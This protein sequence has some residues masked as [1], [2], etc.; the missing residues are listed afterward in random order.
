LSIAIIIPWF[1]QELKGGAE[2]YAWQI[3]TRL[4]IRGH[5]IHI[6]TTCC[7]SFLDD[8]SVNHLP[9][10]TTHEAGL[11]IHRFPVDS[12]DAQSFDKLNGELLGQPSQ[13]FLPGVSPVE[14][15]RAS[16][17]TNQ[18]INSSALERYLTK[19]KNDYQAF[20]FLPYL[21]GPILRGLPLVAQR[22]WLQPCLHDEAY[23]YLPDVAH[24]T[25]QAQILLFNSDG[26]KQLAARLYGPMIHAKSMVVGGGIERDFLNVD[27]SANLPISIDESPFLLCLGRRDPGKGTDFLVNA[28]RQYYQ[29]HKA[30]QLKLI[31]A[32]PGE[33]DY[34][35]HENG[36]YDLGLIS[37]P[38]KAAVLQ[39]CKALCQPS[40]NESYSRVLFEA[41]SCNKP[42][43]AH[44][45]CLATA[46]AVKTSSGGW[47]ASSIEEWIE[48]ITR[49]DNMDSEQCNRCGEKGFSYATD[50][51]DWDKAMERYE[52]LLDLES[53]SRHTKSRLA[54]RSLTIHQ[55]LPNLSFGDAI[56]NE[57]VRIRNWLRKAGYQSN[58]YV[59]YIDP[60]MQDQCECI[61]SSA[62]KKRDAIIYHHSIGSEIT[63][64]AKNHSGPKL[65]IYHNITPAEFFK[66]WKP[67][68]AH[69]LNRGREELWTLARAFPLSV[70]VSNYNAE[71]LAIHGFSDPGVLPL[72]IDPGAW[73]TPPDER[74]MRG[75]Q[76]GKHNILFV[77][78]Y[79]PN[80][81]QHDLLEA[82]AHYQD[83]EPHSR[84]I[85]VGNGEP[86]DPYVQYLQQRIDQSGLRE[87]VILPGHIDDAKLQAYYRTA[88]LYWSMSEHEGFCV[89]LIEA[90]WFDLPIL[91]FR[92]S[93]IPETLLDAGLMFQQKNELPTLAALAQKIILGS[94]LRENIIEHQKR[95]REDFLPSHVEKPF[96]KIVESMSKRS[97]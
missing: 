4:S 16:I 26:E 14:Q 87:H 23:A 62:I 39:S 27:H 74:T 51:G 38:E 91:A 71:E 57:A 60:R 81:C 66:P 12:R 68:F 83:I 97:N 1:G 24:I 94:K 93:A 7:R 85:L 95:R 13:N 22:A 53:N 9:P 54:S 46:V 70:G 72:A 40:T 67:D 63:P 21:Y 45:D 11:V 36:I 2:Q 52:K 75:M 30:T 37:E 59:R 58:I 80:K 15:E 79:A 92:S 69:L 28:F 20:L 18:N 76:D 31:L 8:W 34:S 65:L 29:Q 19:H 56:S 33:H 25:H 73:N 44:R 50:L 89:P 43:I 41:W 61:D 47:V 6:L 82:F 90:M 48:Q 86:G 10:G 84:L 88:H 55:L 3:A 78:R 49:I 64:I 96:L 17:W 32:G 5:D 35:D 42:V 77:G